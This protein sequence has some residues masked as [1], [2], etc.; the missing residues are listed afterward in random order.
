M[1]RFLVN[2]DDPINHEVCMKLG[3]HSLTPLLA[4][5]LPTLRIG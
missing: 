3:Q 4:H 2:I 5:N 1:E